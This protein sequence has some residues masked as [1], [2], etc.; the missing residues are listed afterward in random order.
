MPRERYEDVR[1][2]QFT[3]EHG[4]PRPGRSRRTA[5]QVKLEGG[6]GAPAVV[7]EGAWPLLLGLAKSAGFTA[8]CLDEKGGSL[9]PREALA[10][11][12][13]VRRAVGDVLDLCAA[14]TAVNI[15]TERVVE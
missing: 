11:A 1:D 8:R 4:Q 6:V 2:D 3:V 7:A 5:R 14:G 10:L 13:C 9:S 15:T 12:R